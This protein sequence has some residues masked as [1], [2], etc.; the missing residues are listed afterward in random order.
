MSGTHSVV[1]LNWQR[2]SVGG[3]GYRCAAAVKQ[4]RLCEAH[5]S[6]HLEK[7]A[8]I[9]TEVQACRGTVRLWED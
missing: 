9:S 7:V 5:V 3:E 6:K 8:H 2:N 1:Y 4:M